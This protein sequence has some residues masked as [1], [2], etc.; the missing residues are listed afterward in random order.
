MHIYSY[1]GYI[2][3]EIEA[4]GVFFFYFGFASQNILVP[5]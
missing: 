2:E 4:R 5:K 3:K 1:T